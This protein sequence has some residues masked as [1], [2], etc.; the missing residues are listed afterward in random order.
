PGALLGLDP[1]AELETP[2]PL[3]V[4]DL[5]ELREPADPAAPPLK[6]LAPATINGRIDP[7]GDEDRFVFAVTPGQAYKV[8]VQPADLGSALGGALQVLKPDGAQI[9]QADDTTLPPI[10]GPP[11]AGQQPPPP[12]LT[13]D[14][15]VNVTVPG[16]LTEIVVALRDLEGR[17]G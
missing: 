10:G 7:A 16:G 8:R 6:A 1:N 4:S 12:I 14:P 9:A 11:K 17:G 2:G 5:P 15:S 13:P 3:V